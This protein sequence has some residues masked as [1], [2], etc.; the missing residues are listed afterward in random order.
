M[1]LIGYWI[2]KLGGGSGGGYWGLLGV[3]YLVGVGVVELVIM[4]G[5]VCLGILWC[6]GCILGVGSDYW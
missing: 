6:S 5:W 4:F 1:V 3:D 2:G